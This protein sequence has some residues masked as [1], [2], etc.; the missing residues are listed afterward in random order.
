MDKPDQEQL[1]KMEHPEPDVPYA[2]PLQSRYVHPLANK[3]WSADGIY[4][5]LWGSLITACIGPEKHCF[6]I[7]KNLVCNASDFFKAACNGP[8]KEADGVVCL[9]EQDPKIFKHFIYW[10]YT[11]RTRGYYYPASL[12]PTI[13]DLELL[14]SAEL[15]SE[16]LDKLEDLEHDNIHGL[17]LN[18]A[19]YRDVPFHAIIA[20]YVLADVLQIKGLKDQVITILISIYGYTDLKNR[21]G[22]SLLFWEW[23]TNRMPNVPNWLRGPSKGINMAWNMLPKGCHLR[24]L[25][26]ILFCD[27]ALNFKMR[28]GEEFFNPDFQEEAFS[29]M[30][31]RWY[32]ERGTTRW[33][34][35]L[36]C[37]FHEHDVECLLPSS[38][39]SRGSE[40]PDQLYLEDSD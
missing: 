31:G 2:V 36:I 7:H 4:S 32:Q 23:D 14:V 33:S 35:G 1:A 5:F 30:A 22:R 37:K 11:G 40:I 6:P 28:T 26:I 20:L 17:A 38:K 25:L 27:N 21:E 9:P 29:V 10:L 18:L 39:D 8:F 15:K 13:K 34:D 24:R 12:K 3:E 19:N 16:S